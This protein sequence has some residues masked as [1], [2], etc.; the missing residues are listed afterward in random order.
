[1]KRNNIFAYFFPLKVH[2]TCYF[3]IFSTHTIFFFCQNFIVLLL[4]DQNGGNIYDLKLSQETIRHSIVFFF[5]FFN[6]ITFS[7][8]LFRCEMDGR[9]MCM[10]LTC[11]KNNYPCIIDLSLICTDIC[12]GMG[13]E[14]KLI[15]QISSPNISFCWRNLIRFSSFS[16]NKIILLSYCI[17]NL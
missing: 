16:Q 11:N 2:D 10:Y 14:V 3:Y 5:F 9:E 6:I 15:K 12:K 4:I 8:D 13:E 7:F 17:Y 1:M